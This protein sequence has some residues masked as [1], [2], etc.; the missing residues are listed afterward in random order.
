VRPPARARRT[1][2]L[3]S[4][5]GTQRLTAVRGRR[6]SLAGGCG[7]ARRGAEAGGHGTGEGHRAGEGA[8]RGETEE[9]GGSSRA[10]A[11][12]Q[13]QAG[14]REERVWGLGVGREREDRCGLQHEQQGRRARHAGRG[15][16]GARERFEDGD[17]T[18]E[19]RVRERRAGEHEARARVAAEREAREGARREGDE[20]VEC[21]V[22]LE[23]VSALGDAEKMHRVPPAAWGAGVGMGA[24]Q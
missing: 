21:V 15:E 12:E 14:E 7:A 19:A 13:Q 1:R 6:C 10:A 4:G 18:E 24:G 23:Q 11:L 8:A 16:D 20:R 2:A 5:A 3:Q 9:G 22:V 17:G